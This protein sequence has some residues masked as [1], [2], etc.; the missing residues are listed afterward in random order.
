MSAADDWT[1]LVFALKEVLER[2]ATPPPVAGILAAIGAVSWF[3]GRRRTGFTIATCGILL[4]AA[5]STGLV[6]S[7]LLRPLEDRY[8]GITDAHVLVPAPQY[9]VVLGAGY[10]PDAGLPVTA[11]LDA[12]AVVRLAEGVILLRQLPQ[13]RLIVSGGS[14][15]GNPAS[16]RGY[17]RA[18]EALGV[19]AGSI[20]AI[21][22]PRTT[23]EEIR[24]LS[25]RVHQAPV[26]LVTSAFHMPRAMAYCALFH[27]LAIPAPTGNLT[28]PDDGRSLAALVPSAGG[29]RKTEGRAFRHATDRLESQSRVALGIAACNLLADNLAIG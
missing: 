7:S 3:L 13:A 23:E 8:P 14:V 18:A 26:L 2:L 1:L 11:A 24:A 6:G 10:H 15:G 25:E 27:V 19:P 12:D 28:R 4:V 5:A 22:T 17:A 21:D 29:L 9:I 20:E 16:A